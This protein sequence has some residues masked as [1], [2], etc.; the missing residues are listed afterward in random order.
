MD[1]FKIRQEATRHVGADREPR[2]AEGVR[3]GRVVEDKEGRG[4]D[5]E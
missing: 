5:E 1:A 3:T 2:T 4:E